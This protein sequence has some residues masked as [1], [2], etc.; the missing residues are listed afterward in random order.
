MK[1]LTFLLLISSEL[2]AMAMKNTTPCDFL[3][4]ILKFIVD[5]KLENQNFVA[6]QRKFGKHCDDKILSLK[7]GESDDLKMRIIKE[8]TDQFRVLYIDIS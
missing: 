6:Y 1:I 8:N 2:I 3:G 4:I 5:K 7:F